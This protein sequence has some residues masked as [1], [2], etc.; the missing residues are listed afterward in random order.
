MNVTETRQVLPGDLLPDIAIDEVAPLDVSAPLTSIND[1]MS[2]FF[3]LT[4]YKGRV[5]CAY[6]IHAILAFQINVIL[7]T[8]SLLIR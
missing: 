6:I 7:L 3:Y 1:P 8:K 2:Q 4:F 5:R